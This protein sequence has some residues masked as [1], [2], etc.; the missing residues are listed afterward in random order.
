[1]PSATST[2]LG[3]AAALSTQARWEDALQEAVSAAREALGG[4]PDLAM[5]FVSPHHAAAADHIA[6]E[7][8]QLL[9]TTNLLGCTGEAIA[10]T[11]REVEEEPAL[12]LWL[13][14]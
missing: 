10:G 13:A 2:A 4:T 14:R 1:M 11:A 5:L 12:S 6:A 3:C 8:C 7:A 9:G